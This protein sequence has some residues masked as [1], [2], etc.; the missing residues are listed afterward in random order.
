MYGW[1][2]WHNRRKSRT[3]QYNSGISR[4]GIDWISRKLCFYLTKKRYDGRIIISPTKTRQRPFAW[5]WWIIEELTLSKKQIRSP[6][7]N[8]VISISVWQPRNEQCK[9]HCN[10]HYRDII[11]HIFR[12][13]VS[14]DR[15][16]RTPGMV[17]TKSRWWRLGLQIQTPEILDFSLNRT[18]KIARNLNIYFR[19]KFSNDSSK[20]SAL[21][22]LIQSLP[23]DFE[24]RNSI[25]LR[26]HQHTDPIHIIQRDYESS[27][28]V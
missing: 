7:Y 22:K 16:Q 19:K 9:R 20:R 18:T 6:D 24:Y 17:Q 23:I 25:H 2:S 21:V 3:W 12:H 14:E 4:H 15:Y 27:P 5:A 13:C 26:K 1:F 28:K 8:H 11:N 10:C